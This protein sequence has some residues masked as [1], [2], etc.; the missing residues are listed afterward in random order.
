[1]E[2]SNQ[3]RA[4]TI[5]RSFNL[6]VLAFILAALF[7]IWKKQD[8]YAI[9]LGLGL[10]VLLILCFFLNFSYVSFKSER[11]KVTL[12]YYSLITLFGREYSSIDFPHELLFRYKLLK[13]F[14]LR[15][16]TLTVKTQ[17]GVADYPT[18]SLTGLSKKE[19]EQINTE[20][21]RI[22][23]ENGLAKR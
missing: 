2:I 3:K 10:L 14:P 6:I 15:E 16:L 11:G 18:V 7:F 9:Y 4:K 21:E 19:V 13:G 1:M 20:L 12:R 23:F 17:R 5:K 8:I 22:L